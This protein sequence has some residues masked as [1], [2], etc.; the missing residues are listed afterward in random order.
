MKNT[1]VDW[2]LKTAKESRAYKSFLLENNVNINLIKDNNSFFK[3][4]P[5]SNKK[6]YIEKFKVKDLAISSIHR[7]TIYASS[8]SSGEPTYWARS[9]YEDIIGRDRHEFFVNQIFNIK[10]EESTLVLICFSM[11]MWIAG[12]YTAS[13]FIGVSRNGY[14]L[15]IATP[16]I[17][18]K[19]IYNL[20]RRLSSDFENII[21]A[22]YPPFLLDL[23]RN[24]KDENIKIPKKIFF[25]GSG[26]MFSEEA[27][28]EISAI[29][30]IQ[31]PEK[32]F[33]DVYGSADAG[34]MAFETPLSIILR[35]LARKNKELRQSLFGESTFLPLLAQ[36][37][38]SHIF[39]ENVDRELVLTRFGTIPLIRYAIHDIGRIIKYDEMQTILKKLGLIKEIGKVLNKNYNFPF[40]TVHGRTDV[41]LTFY[42]LNIY[43][44]NLSMVLENKNI[45]P[46][47]TGSYGVYT[48][49]DLKNKGQQKFF[50]RLE[51]KNKLKS[52]KI[53]KSK[54]TDF[55]SNSLAHINSEY[56]KLC[57]IMPSEARP[58]LELFNYEDKN[59]SNIIG[60]GVLY[61]KGK[62]PKMLL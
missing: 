43:P 9:K 20:L 16:G 48:K 27:R 38:E 31:F 29:C 58:I 22:G 34:L 57:E 13:S 61:V 53:L 3:Y 21:I 56:R 19:E 45:K 40:I 24:F 12:G 10:K 25:L 15:T 28:D 8:G 23:C 14:N 41:A 5:I 37:D 55:F 51:L 17:D 59:F 62:K 33:I 35:R 32:N 18:K 39:F 6:N 26:D 46:W 11:G 49:A 54:I 47:V 52:S 30:R 7:E 60:R 1:L 50:V 42:A 44:E 2:F 36:Y 4:V